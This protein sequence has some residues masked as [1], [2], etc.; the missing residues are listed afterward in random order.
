MSSMYC[1]LACLGEEQH[2]LVWS[3]YTATSHKLCFSDAL[4]HVLLSLPY[5]LLQYKMLCC[6]W[7]TYTC[8]S[9]LGLCIFGFFCALVP[10][11]VSLQVHTAMHT[12]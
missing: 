4:L 5:G 6:F 2:N 10:I 7:H 3:L 8:S 11:P 12:I 1:S 9:V